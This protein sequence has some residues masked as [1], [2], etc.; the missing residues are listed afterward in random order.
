MTERKLPVKVETI[1]LN[2][3]YKGWEF[4]CRT[5]PPWGDFVN[6][7]VELD[8]VD[9][10]KP[11]EAN[12]KLYELLSYMVTGW[13]FV[14]ENGKDIPF[15]RKGFDKVPLDLIRE[16]IQRAREAIEK[17]PLAPNAS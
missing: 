7:L 10:T 11:A 9:Q 16:T 6:K 3:D 12:D 4:T 5:N 15:N 14:D 13:N 1:Q 17:I 2:G 8:K